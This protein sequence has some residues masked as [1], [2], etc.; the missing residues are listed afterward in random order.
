LDVHAPHER[1]HGLKDFTVHLL[2]ITVGLLIAVGIEGLVALHR[3]HTLV[4]EA[5][6]ML[7]EEIEYNG[8]QMKDAEAKARLQQDAIAK[9]IAT[10]QTILTNPKDKAAQTANINADFQ[11]VGLRDTAWKTAQGTGALSYMPYVEAQR[12]SDLYGDQ[13]SFEEQQAKILEDE[14]RFLG[15]VAKTNFGHG[16]VTSE[17]AAQA[18]EVFGQWQA[19]LAYLDLSARLSAANDEAFLTGKEG[20]NSMHESLG[21]GGK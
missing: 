10:L 11:I 2:T 9:D 19:H 21:G 13:K 20:P 6:E 17:Q 3:E 14:A 7:R 12:Y 15:V 5:R 8:R 4:R 1:I 18:L 16:D